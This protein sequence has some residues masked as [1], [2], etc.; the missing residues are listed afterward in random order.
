[1]SQCLGTSKT[2]RDEEAVFDQPLSIRKFPF[3]ATRDGIRNSEDWTSPR[4]LWTCHHL[5]L[6]TLLS[7]ARETHWACILSTTPRY[8]LRPCWDPVSSPYQGEAFGRGC[9]ALNRGEWPLLQHFLGLLIHTHH[10]VL[11]DAQ[12]ARHQLIL[13]F[14]LFLKQEI[15]RVSALPLNTYL[16]LPSHQRFHDVL[17]EVTYIYNVSK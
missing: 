14:H 13:A 2:T 11:G 4:P 15:P 1:M 7:K 17:P 6:C 5:S 9:P 10:W 16:I 8:C 12:Q 3:R